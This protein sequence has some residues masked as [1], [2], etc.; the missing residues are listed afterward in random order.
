[1]ELELSLFAKAL[2]ILHCVNLHGENIIISQTYNAQHNQRKITTRNEFTTDGN[3][4][5][6]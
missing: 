1:M 3:T 5:H 4:V 2:I 6:K